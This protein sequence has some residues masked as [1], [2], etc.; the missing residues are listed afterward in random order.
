MLV[1]ETYIIELAKYKIADNMPSQMY[2]NLFATFGGSHLYRTNTKES[3]CDIIVVGIPYLQYMFPYSHNYFYGFDDNVPEFRTKQVKDDI[4]DITY[5]SLPTYLK[6]LAENNPNILE[7][8]ASDMVIFCDEWFQILILENKA[9]LLNKKLIRDKFIGY[10][11]SQLS[12]L[13]KKRLN[14]KRLSVV[15]EFGYDTKYAMHTVRLLLYA[16]DLL[17]IQNIRF[18]DYSQYLLD[19]KLGKFDLEYIRNS[20]EVEIKNIDERYDKT[21]LVENPNASKMRMKEKYTKL[22]YHHDIKI[23]TYKS[24]TNNE[25]MTFGESY[26]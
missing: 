2:M 11:K 7:T 23:P 22:L 5:Y 13:E 15:E 21:F 24:I 26:L 12:K 20:V 6:L 1:T 25:S 8:V 9:E 19:I 4:F 14:S 17:K 3:D 10:A 16:I 18:D